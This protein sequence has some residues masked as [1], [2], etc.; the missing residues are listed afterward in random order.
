MSTFLQFLEQ[1]VTSISLLLPLSFTVLTLVVIYLIFKR[2]PMGSI[3]V[4]LPPSPPRLPVIGNLLQLG[5]HPHRSLRSLAQT[6]GPIMLLRFG[7]IPVLIV[8]SAEFAREIMKS[9]D[10]AFANRPKSIVF[11]KLLYNYKDVSTAPYGEYWRQV[12]SLCVMNLLSNK[13]VQSYRS[14]REEEVVHMIEKINNFLSSSSLVNLSQIFSSVTNDIVCRVAMGR[15]YSGKDEGRSFKELLGEFVELLGVVNVG[16]YIPWLKWLGRVSGLVRRLEKVAKEFDSFLDGVVE[17]HLGRDGRLGYVQSEEK[18]DFVDVLL[19]IQEENTAGFP[20]D[21]TSVKAI[22]LDTFA[23]G[24]HT[25]FTVLEWAM[26]ELLRHPEVLKKLQ[27][28]V[29]EIANGNSFVTEDDMS[30]MHYLKAVIKETL[31]LHPPIPL[32]VPRESTQ[33]VQIKGFDILPGTQVFIN[34]WAIGRAHESWDQPE[35]FRPERFLNCAVDF[36]GHD[37]NLIPFGSGRRSCP[38]VEF[39]FS[40]DQ[41]VLAN[42]VYKFN[43]ASPSGSKGEDLDTSESTGITVHRKFPLNAIATPYPC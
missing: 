18:E 9:H 5:M 6:Y 15:K 29:R 21:R 25:T 8:S 39:A 41:V 32:L 12:K 24:T 36:R 33:H 16:D 13:R 14:V 3:D 20:I 40:V 35:V 26:T 19:R 1:R 38:G 27:K 37:F 4:L 7:N 17:E 22:I 31:R 28:E 2:S 42:I 11:E 34:V 43:W 23:A 10:L 30:Q